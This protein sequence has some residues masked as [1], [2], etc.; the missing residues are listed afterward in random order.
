[1]KKWIV[2]VAALAACAATAAI[3]L[4]Q[5]GPTL[6]LYE[7]EGY[8]GDVRRIDRAVRDL[9]SVRFNDSARSL[10]AEGRWEVCLDA[11]FRGQCRVVQGQVSDM[12]D[13]NGSVSSVRYLGPADWGAARGP[14]TT[15]GASV[16]VTPAVTSV[17]PVEDWQPM[18]RTDLFGGDYREF[19]L[20]SGQD[21]R[22]CRTACEADGR[23]QSWT[24]TIPGSTPY[25]RCYLKNTVPAPNEGECCISG[26]KGATSSG[27]PA[28][29]SGA[30]GSGA[31]RGRQAG[32]AESAAERAARV[33]A[34]EA[35][36]RAHDRI[37]EGVG[38]LF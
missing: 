17:S 26:I 31:N 37:R 2:G 1:M 35:E 4:A 38:R 33:A 15:S 24:M 30:T 12:G 7:G 8:Q 25:G 10:I 3:A 13:W 14:A 20:A 28:N 36:R 9:S 11:N 34:E 29:V 27:G 6:T 23:C 21:W 18:F 19:D 16:P 5:S 32:G 22:A